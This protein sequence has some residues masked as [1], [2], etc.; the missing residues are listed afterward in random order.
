MPCKLNV[1]PHMPNENIAILSAASAVSPVNNLSSAVA[2]PASQQHV[3]PTSRCISLST[4][5]GD[6]S[7]QALWLLCVQAPTVDV[8]SQA[9]Y[10]CSGT[11]VIDMWFQQCNMLS[12]VPFY[13]LVSP[14]LVME[15]F[16]NNDI[17]RME[18]SL[19]LNTSLSLSEG[20]LAAYQS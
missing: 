6:L 14:L 17:Q 11:A 15:Y 4:V 18:S 13:V 7:G 3:V 9:F 20:L 1:H 5:A 8:F 10:A 2:C 12:C 19:Q 16:K